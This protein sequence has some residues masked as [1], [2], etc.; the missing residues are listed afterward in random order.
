MGIY[1]KPPTT[2]DDLIEP[3]SADVRGA[4]CTLRKAVRAAVPDAVET[5]SGG[6]SV[7]HALYSIGHATNVVCVIQPSAN[8][9]K[10]YLHRVARA[11]APGLVLEGSGKN[12]LHVKVA[13]TKSAASADIAAA[14][15]LAGR[16]I[17]R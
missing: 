12:S 8:H 10:L 14:L 15:T 13:S 7:G 9:C 17:Q 16:R 5:V 6:K 2:F 3:F 1:A 4:A 11:D